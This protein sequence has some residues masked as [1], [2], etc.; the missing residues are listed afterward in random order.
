MQFFGT[1]F[2]IPDS[3]PVDYLNGFLKGSLDDIPK[4]R[5]PFGNTTSSALDAIDF[6]DGE[7]EDFFML[8][9]PSDAV[10]DGATTALIYVLS[11]L[12]ADDSTFFGLLG[13]AIARFMQCIP[14]LAHMV[15]TSEMDR[16]ALLKPG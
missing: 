6:I 14:E 3:I 11:E 12:K 4:T 2:P 1:A 13:G 15:D 5:R 10:C 8:K 16:Q 7:L 9:D